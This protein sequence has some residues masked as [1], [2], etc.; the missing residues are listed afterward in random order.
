MNKT[1][2]HIIL[3]VLALVLFYFEIRFGSIKMSAP[4]FWERLGSNDPILFDFRLPAALTAALAGAC[5]SLSGWLLQTLFRNPLAGP[6]ILGITSGSSLMV[7]F[8]LLTGV[9]FSGMFSFVGVVVSALIGAFSVL[10]LILVVS[11]R[12]K[13]LAT[14]LIF[15]L[16]ISYLLG[17]FQSILIDAAGKSELKSFVSW[18]LA[19]FGNYKDGQIYVLFI[20]LIIGVIAVLKLGAKLDFWLLGEEYAVSLGVNVKLF[21]LTLLGVCGLLA[22]VVTAYCGPV[23]FLG[24]AMPHAVRLFYKEPNHLKFVSVLILA[25]A[26]AGMF[27]ELISRMPWSSRALPLN[28]VTSF[29][30]A[31]VVIWL[32]FKSRKTRWN[33]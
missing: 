8:V 15:G 13:Q 12:V 21:R 6:S 28:A 7:A 11:S 17:A 18:G 24:L 19:S 22:G 1:L 30:G 5:L 10:L 9:T 25:G 20:S 29:L 32:L 4:D 2:I 3:V 27:C 26:C 23:A 14:V 16:M 31:P 33:R